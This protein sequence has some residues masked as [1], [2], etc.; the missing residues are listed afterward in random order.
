MEGQEG[1][2]FVIVDS[3]DV[4][5]YNAKGILPLS[6][7]EIAKIRQWLRPTAYAA[8]SSEYKKHLN[9]YL[10][11]T[12]EW[13][14][15][16]ET[17]HKWH[18]SPDHGA[19]WIKA[20]PGAGKSVFAAMIAS[21]L[22]STEK[23]PLL[24]FFFRQIVTTNHHPQSLCRDFIAQLLDHSPVLQARMKEHGDYRVG[25]DGVSTSAL[26]AYLTE[27]LKTIPKV[28]CV[29]DALD[30]MDI[31]QDS[32]FQDFLRLGKLRPSSIKLLMTSRPLPRIEQA[33]KDSSVLQIRLG[34][35]FVDKDITLY[36]DQRLNQRPDFDKELRRAVKDEI[37]GKSQGSFLYAR[38]MMDELTS[39]F[40]QMIPDIKFIQ[41]SLDWLPVTL[42]DMYNGMLLDHS[43]R[44]R[45]P[46]DLQVTILRW[47][48]HSTR[49]LRL[50]ELATML[51]SVSGEKG[52][53][54]K[55][56]V[57][58]ACGPLLEILEDETVSVI[59]HSFTEF[60]TDSSREGRN[61]PGSV[62]PQFPVIDPQTTHRVLATTCLRYLASGCLSNW[63]NPAT[64]CEFPLHSA[65]LLE[66]AWNQHAV[67]VPRLRCE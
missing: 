38:L 20:I 52:K 13:I 41:R 17:F 32:F 61:A 27:A 35:Q 53:D 56:V 11:G 36:V 24:F 60:L 39:H 58:A 50:L 34:Q 3:E 30:E 7:E 62:H 42:E 57:R 29:V 45:V 6:Q 43:L 31:D 46:Q 49:P 14:Q 28:Y 65:S 10:P 55:A 48:T 18:D 37:G 4:R 64:Q 67:S 9:S 40:D 25:I 47:V 66:T 15:N 26:W 8:E 59:H 63:G 1:H 19:L 21:K 33:L 5:D 16:T 23:I 44:S 2:D 54:T 12:G 51:D 22:A